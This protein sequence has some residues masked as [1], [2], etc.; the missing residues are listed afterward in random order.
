VPRPTRRPPRTL[1]LGTWLATRGPLAAFSFIVAALGTAAAIVGAFAM[2][3]HGGGTSRVPT[4]TAE[5]ISWCA[6]VTLAFGAA[7]R[8]VERDREQ[9]VLALVRARGVGVGAYVRGRVGG[10][11]LV[12]AAMVGGATL[13]AGLATTSMGASSM[14]AVR[15]W[16]GALAYAVA[17]AATLGPVAMAS[18]GTGSRAGGYFTLLTVL[19]LPEL[20]SPWTS[21]LLPRGWHELTSIPAALDAVRTGVSA[22]LDS[23]ARGA[24]AIAALAAVIAV[25]V[26]VVGAQVARTEAEQ[27]E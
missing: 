25:S 27:A 11:V 21:A 13:I 3:R 20:V 14:A 15:S 18:L 4:L 6:G 9:G 5:G 7:L 12:L 17:F 2:G 16:A 24:R 1:A 10:L 22:P 26:V 8:A 23:G 19:V